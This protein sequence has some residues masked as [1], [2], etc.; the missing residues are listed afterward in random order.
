MNFVRNS[1]PP[2][3]MLLANLSTHNIFI[4]LFYRYR[5]QT[6]YKEFENIWKIGEN[7]LNI[8]AIIMAH[9]VDKN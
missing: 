9:T 4:S 8:D 5:Y 3:L 2:G 7:I 6:I 1:Y